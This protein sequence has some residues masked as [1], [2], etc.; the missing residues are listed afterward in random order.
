MLTIVDYAEIFDRR[1]VLLLVRRS[2]GCR[3]LVVQGT[4]ACI[5]LVVVRA[6]RLGRL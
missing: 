3:A 6:T 1:L 4:V 2:C 5:Y